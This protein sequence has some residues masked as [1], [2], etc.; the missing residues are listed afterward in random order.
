M[1]L[2]KHQNNPRLWLKPNDEGDVQCGWL[3]NNTFSNAEKKNLVIIIRFSPTY[4]LNGQKIPYL[5]LN[6]AF[7]VFISP[8]DLRAMYPNKIS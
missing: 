8:T 7:T 3:E 1:F 5:R 6:A 2:L 4:L